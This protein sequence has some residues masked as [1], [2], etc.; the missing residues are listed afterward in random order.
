MHPPPG[1]ECLFITH[2]SFLCF[3]A[4]QW[5]LPQSLTTPTVKIKMS[6][7]VRFSKVLSI[8]LPLHSPK[9]LLFSKMLCVQK[10]RNHFFYHPVKQNCCAN[11][12]LLYCPV[13]P[14]TDLSCLAC[15]CKHSV[16]SLLNNGRIWV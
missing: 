2:L 5:L 7:R 3:S 12:V 6:F 15:F 4:T 9:P 14:R 10:A 16:S 1:S 13:L 11:S 8:G